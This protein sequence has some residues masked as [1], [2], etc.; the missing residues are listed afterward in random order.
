MITCFI[1]TRAQ[2]I[3]M[4]PVI[5][6]IERRKLDLNL[7]FTGQH[8][9]TMEQLV[10]DFGIRTRAIYLYQGREITGITQM[11]K[12]F[13]ACLWKAL[14]HPDAFVPKTAP[15]NITL[16]HGDTFST[17]LGAVVGRLK[18]IPVAHIEAGL[19]SHNV[20]HPFPEELTR[21]IVFRLSRVAFCPGPW[22]YDNMRRYRSIRID[23]GHNTLRDAIEIAKAAPPKADP[24]LTA[25]DYGICSIHRFENIFDRKRLAK[26]LAL[27]EKA[28]ARYRLLFV[29]HPATRKKL[30]QFGFMS[31]LEANPK[32][33][34][35]PRMGYVEF[36]QLMQRA[37][38]VVTDGGGNQEELSY[39][40]IPTLLMRKATE[41]REGLGSTAIL[42]GYDEGVMEFFLAGLDN[43]A[44]T[45]TSD[46]AA[47]TALPSRQIV[48]YIESL[49]S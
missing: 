40:G 42:S 6:E 3:K 14:R 38:F 29:L 8:K 32:I 16:V 48:D 25:G 7:V 47:G 41:R 34:L 39:L 12:W 4:A 22:A 15:P 36:V 49:Q 2:L 46:L 5:L 30:E 43:K 13:L 11:A 18:G 33:K 20:F 10:S 35:L 24:G 27:V 28:A 21:L 9:E 44:P 45:P 1:G 17:L 19:R 26:I 31:R 23:T 37:R